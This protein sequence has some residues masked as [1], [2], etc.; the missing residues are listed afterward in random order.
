MNGFQLNIEAELWGYL[1]KDP[2]FH[3]YKWILDLSSCQD[4]V[5][6][7]KV[8]ECGGE[9]YKKPSVEAITQIT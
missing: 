9:R 4:K 2:I 5:E 1:D 8:R 3:E 7:S 6:K